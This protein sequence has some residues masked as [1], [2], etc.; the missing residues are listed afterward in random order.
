MFFK[1]FQE[2]L[3]LILTEVSTGGRQGAANPAQI[4]GWALQYSCQNTQNPTEFVV[5]EFQLLKKTKQ[6][7]MG[8]ASLG[9]N[10]FNSRQR[11]VRNLG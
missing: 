6:L 9:N 10:S 7:E 2:N 11:G 4:S 5:K 8:N 1:G 3:Y